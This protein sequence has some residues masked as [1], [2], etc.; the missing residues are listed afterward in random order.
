MI[1]TANPNDVVYK[2]L[3]RAE[4]RRG[5]K[6]RKNVINGEPDRLADLLEEAADEI[7]WLRNEVAAAYIEI[8]KLK[9]RVVFDRGVHQK[10]KEF[11]E[12][13]YEDFYADW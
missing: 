3:K 7:K 8:N 12:D 11:C 4:I 13:F 10:V 6:T 1:T 9:P 5:I 2:L